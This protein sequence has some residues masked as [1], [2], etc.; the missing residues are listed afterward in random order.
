MIHIFGGAIALLGAFVAVTAKL[1]DRAHKW[2]V[3]GGR[4]FFYGMI[5]VFLT[6]LPMT[7]LKP[8][9]F[10]FLIAIFS[11][12]LTFFGWRYATNRK[13]QPSMADRVGIIIM[14]IAGT[15]MIGWGVHLAWFD[16]G[17]G[18]TLIV[19][20]IIG[21]SLTIQDYQRFKKGPL[22]A[23][24]RISAH[25]TMMMAATIAA[26]TAFLVTNIQTNPV[27]ITWIAPTVIITPIIIWMN[28]RLYS[29]RSFIE[30]IP[31]P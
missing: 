24:D 29:G 20:G 15:G 5:V 12:Y 18:I 7:I 22:R 26:I 9:L 17:N 11:F 28:K 3:Y 21:L 27:W 25:P 2:H 8:N 14:G 13:G 19:F 23:K 31:K 10:L 6:A 1:I 30:G 4:T 16:D